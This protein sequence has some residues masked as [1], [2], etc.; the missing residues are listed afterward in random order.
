MRLITL[1]RWVKKSSTIL[2]SER[3]LNSAKKELE[4]VEASSEFID[5]LEVLLERKVVGSVKAESGSDLYVSLKEV[6]EVEDFG[7]FADSLSDIVDEIRQYKLEQGDSPVCYLNGVLSFLSLVG[8][9]PRNSYVAVYR[10][11]S[12]GFN[13]V[14]YHC[15]DPG[16]A[17]KP[18][19]EKASGTLIMSGTLSPIQIFTEIL[20]LK[21]AEIRSYS[22]IVDPNNVRTIID[23]YVT[24]PLHGERGGI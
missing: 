2:L 3:G 12:Y 23:S 21:G 24:N 9:S 17:I 10:R 11:S 20:G 19:S 4:A 16:L 22:A 6:L 5:E 18:V 8:S 14:E 7:F 15:L 13:L 1:T